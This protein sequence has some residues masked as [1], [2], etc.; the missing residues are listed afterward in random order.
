MLSEIDQIDMEI[1][2]IHD[3]CYQA[4]CTE[5]VATCP[6]SIQIEELKQKRFNLEVAIQCDDNW[7]EY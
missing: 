2:N 5:C 4:N 7:T 3:Q 6:L 1:H